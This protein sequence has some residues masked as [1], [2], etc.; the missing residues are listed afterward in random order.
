[1]CYVVRKY[2][3][4]VLACKY[5]TNIRKNYYAYNKKIKKLSIF[6]F[7]RKYLEYYTLFVYICV[8]I[9]VIL[10]NQRHRS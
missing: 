3:F 4:F 5:C 9:A 10:I 7:L 2:I 6:R 1:M 8:I